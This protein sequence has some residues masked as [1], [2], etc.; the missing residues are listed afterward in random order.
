MTN[1]LW[2]CSIRLPGDTLRNYPKVIDAENFADAALKIQRIYG[3]NSI[4]SPP[5][6]MPENYFTVDFTARRY[7]QGDNDRALLY[8]QEIAAY[9]EMLSKYVDDWPEQNS[10]S[11]PE[12]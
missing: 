7:F 5:R 6:I 12:T 11:Q 10:G 1:K 8:I 9:K 2:I 4:V 3:K